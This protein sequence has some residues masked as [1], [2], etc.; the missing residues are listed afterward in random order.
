MLNTKSNKIQKK[1]FVPITMPMDIK[2]FEVSNFGEVR[3]AFTGKILKQARNQKGYLFIQL[4][5]LS[6]CVNRLV[7][8]HFIPNP[9][10]LPYTKHLDGDKTNNHADNLKW[11]DSHRM[12]NT[13]EY[14]AWEQMF[15]RC[16]NLQS[17]KYKYYGARGITVCKEWTGRGGFEKFFA[18]MG[19]RPKGV[20]AKGFPKY[21]IDR[22]N[23]DGNYE[24]DN[25]RWATKKVQNNNTRKSN[26]YKQAV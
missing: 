9:K 25:C 7:A 17:P 15:Q 4:F 24:K 18:D 22:I 20:T 14:S 2:G 26:K 5:G 3:N 13:P 6:I 10:K 12:T 23:N 16:Y 11:N 19:K 1:V 21:S 8:L